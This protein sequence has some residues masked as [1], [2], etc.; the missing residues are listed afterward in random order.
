MRGK[1]IS[2]E[3]FEQ[4]PHT[5]CGII[6][7]WA[8]ET[9]D[10]EA[11]IIYDTGKKYTYK[12]FQ[13]NID[14]IAFKLYNMDFRKG[15]IL[16]TSLPYLAEHII[17]I[18]A[19]AKLGVML[20]PL[21][22]RLKPPEIM[23]C[24]EILQDKAKM[25][26]HLGK[27][28]AANFGMIGAAVKKNN[29]W[30]EYVVQFSS[31]EDKYR[32]GIIPAYEI[33][34]EAQQEYEEAVKNLESMKDYRKECASV[35]GKDPIMIVFTTGSTGFPKPAMIKNEGIVCQNMCLAKA[36]GL[37]VSDKMIVNLPPSHVGGSAEQLMT[38]FFGGGTCIVLHI[39]DAM[40]TL[41]AI[42]KHRATVVGQIPALYAMEWR[43][44]NYSE[45]DVSSLRFVI[46]AGQSVDR[47]FLEKL[48]MMAP[49]IGGGLG[50]TETSGFCTYITVKDDWERFVTAL[51]NDFP[52]Y[53]M[54]IR[55][56]MKVDGTAGEEL[57]KGEIGEICFKGPQTFLG[58]FGN[59]EATDKT[60]SKDGIL[61]TGDMGYID[62]DGLHLEGRRKFLIKPKGYQV[63]PPEVEAFLAEM[64][65]IEDVAVLGGKHEVYSEGIIA[66]IKVK[67]SQ[68]LTREQV[69]EHARGMAAYKRPSLIVFIDEF[70]L[71]RVAKT[72]YVTL[73]DRV[74]KDIEKAR[75]EG[76][77]DAE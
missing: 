9:P 56:P 47:P 38:T 66:Y 24:L 55:K 4:Y 65:Q 30:L 64:P 35:N 60:L 10:K 22:L 40:K 37:E 36:F 76:K 63:F 46:C 23:R 72:D 50:L 52:I 69:M 31:P 19:C 48:R 41:D 68:T 2:Q 49:Q 26:C 77:W 58:Y 28:S 29:P 13:Q 8:E 54:S 67:E 27:T 45:Y 25:Y 32:K 18:Y 11:F 20:T 15:D 53:P 33:M 43:L 7:K 71:N 74:P 42:Q 3:E 34:D 44:P 51:G 75:S 16:I 62:D 73:K 14:I 6:D 39:F 70:P 1:K 5:L 61:Y 21:D 17:L 57:A 12:D 59:E